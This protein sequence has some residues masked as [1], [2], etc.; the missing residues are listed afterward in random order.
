MA[1]PQ[2]TTFPRKWWEWRPPDVVRPMCWVHSWLNQMVH[3]ILPLKPRYNGLRPEWAGGVVDCFH[4]LTLSSCVNG[5]IE[6]SDCVHWA[7]VWWVVVP[8]SENQGLHL[9]KQVH[10]LIA[11][12]LAKSASHQRGSLCP[13]SSLKCS[14]IW[15]WSTTHKRLLIAFLEPWLSAEIT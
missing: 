7:L 8:F 6:G 3:V 12:S 4:V 11:G 5:E 10:R 14:L 9:G 2:C 1:Y 15:L 13:R